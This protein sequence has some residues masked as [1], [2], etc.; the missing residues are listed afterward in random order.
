MEKQTNT[1]TNKTPQKIY[2]IQN[3]MRLKHVYGN[4]NFLQYIMFLWEKHYPILATRHPLNGSYRR[5]K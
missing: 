5:R 4:N 2:S 3:Q 1:P